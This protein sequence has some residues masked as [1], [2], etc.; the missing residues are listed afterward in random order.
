MFG[1]SSFPN[2]LQVN[3]LGN[4]SGLK[5]FHKAGTCLRPNQKVACN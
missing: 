1:D 3:T 4:Y 2:S 5:L